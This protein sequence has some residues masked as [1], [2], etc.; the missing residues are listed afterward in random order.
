MLYY[1]EKLSKTEYSGVVFEQFCIIYVLHAIVCN[2]M[3]YF[4]KS[5]KIRST[6]IYWFAYIEYVIQ[7]YF[8]DYEKYNSG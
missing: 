8:L 3:C 6:S 2:T 5:Q 7:T 4:L 1:I